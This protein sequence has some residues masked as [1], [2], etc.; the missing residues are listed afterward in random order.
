VLDPAGTG[1][2][3]VDLAALRG[4]DSGLRLRD[5]AAALGPGAGEVLVDPAL[6]SKLGIDVGNADEALSV[7][8]SF[9]F[10]LRLRPVD[11]TRFERAAD[12]IAAQKRN[13]AEATIYELSAPGSRQA[14]GP[15][16]A[17]G[18][19][20]ARVAVSDEAAVF[21]RSDEGVED[22]VGAPAD[23]AAADPRLRLAVSCLGDVVAAR[24]FP[25]DFTH[26][27]S[28]SPDLIAIGITAESRSRQILCSINDS[29]ERTNEMTRSVSAAL[30]PAAIDPITRDRVSDSVANVRVTT[31]DGDGAH[32]TKAEIDLAPGAPGDYLFGALTRG[33][34]ITFTGAK[35]PT[36]H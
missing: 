30:R 35:P 5:A 22:L 3:W 34:L 13:D 1:Y 6:R 32:A 27:P 11:T 23:A 2:G 18:S 7:G 10:G 25:G 17:I 21:G 19:L 26:N 14:S 33:S 15:L 20:G 9:A 8:G 16:S 4:A 31:I 36:A 24:T 29:A 12:A 28:A